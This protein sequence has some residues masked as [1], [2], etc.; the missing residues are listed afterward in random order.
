MR[1]SPQLFEVPQPITSASVVIAPK[2]LFSLN[3]NKAY[4]LKEFLSFLSRFDAF[5]KYTDLLE[6][7]SY[8]WEFS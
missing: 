7:T 1:Q 4:I 6:C 8:F 3:E 5:I 2:H